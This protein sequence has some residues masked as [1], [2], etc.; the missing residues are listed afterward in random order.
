PDSQ[1]GIWIYDYY[2]EGSYGVNYH[3]YGCLYDWETALEVC[4]DGW[5]LPSDEEWMELELFLGMDPDEVD[6]IGIIRGEE[7][8][9]CGKLKETGF[10]HWKEPNLGATNEKGFTALPGGILLNDGRFI[11][12]HSMAYFWT[13]NAKSNT[14]SI[15]RFAP[16]TGIDFGRKQIEKNRGL[17]IRC[18]KN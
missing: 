4:P 8:N 2:G 17:S 7:A 3:I 12:L 1:C 18:I 16:Y 9:V 13:S 11:S 15:C 10:N 6:R 5:H 14:Y